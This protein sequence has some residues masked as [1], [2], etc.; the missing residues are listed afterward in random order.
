MGR[1]GQTCLLWPTQCPFLS[2]FPLSEGE[3]LLW[4]LPESRIL[5]ETYLLA[6]GVIRVKTHPLFPSLPFLSF[7]VSLPSV[8]LPTHPSYVHLLYWFKAFLGARLSL[9]L[10]TLVSSSLFCVHITMSRMNLPRFRWRMDGA[11]WK[12]ED[13]SSMYPNPDFPEFCTFE[14]WRLVLLLWKLIP[15]LKLFLA[16]SCTHG[17]LWEQVMG[18]ARF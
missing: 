9:F 7:F 17:T 6:G 11:G 14:N 13:F 2:S 8:L 3:A 12:V 4:F 16:C 18:S 15:I 10:F 1:R 5:T